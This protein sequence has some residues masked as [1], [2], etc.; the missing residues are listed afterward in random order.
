MK[1]V[2]GAVEDGQE[3]TLRELST[4]MQQSSSTSDYDSHDTS[5]DEITHTTSIAGGLSCFYYVSIGHIFCS[6]PPGHRGS[7]IPV[8]G[9][10]SWCP[11]T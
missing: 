4:S 3:L 8:P 6:V 10:K 7:K 2:L 5:G 1:A 9:P 11:D